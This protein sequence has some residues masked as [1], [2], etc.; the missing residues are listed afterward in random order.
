M[1]RGDAFGFFEGSYASL[2]NMA[3][4]EYSGER[5]V[6]KEYLPE[7]CAWRVQLVNPQFK[8]HVMAVKESA[9]CFDW[10]VSPPERLAAL[11]EHLRV[12]NV[13]AAGNALFC[14]RNVEA[15]VEILEEHPVMVV[16]NKNAM[17]ARWTLHSQ[18][19][20]EHSSKYPALLAFK[21]FSDGGIADDYINDASTL[22]NTAHQQLSLTWSTFMAA[23]ET[24]TNLMS[25]ETPPTSPASEALGLEEVR[26]VADVL[27]KWQSNSL[28]VNAVSLEQHQS[29][30]FRF[31]CKANHSCDANCA[32]VFDMNTGCMIFRT[33]RPIKRGEQLTISYFGR[34]PDF[35]FSSSKERRKKLSVRG[36]VCTCSQCVLE[37]GEVPQSALFMYKEELARDVEAAKAAALAEAGAEGCRLKRQHS[38]RRAY[39]RAHSAAA[40]SPR[41]RARG[42][43]SVRIGLNF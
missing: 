1:L 39:S 29:A 10:Y 6:I 40:E 33:K 16:T 7:K 9:L 41:G 26:Q 11:P 34:D 4:A 22:L 15:G 19:L 3:K 38:H 43:S 18:M 17:L 13:G 5:C 20:Q 30:L 32:T 37:G 42:G 21:E 2:A 27:A 24:A 8:G 36:F 12:A 23:V 28:S 35:I 25:A 31:A 14:D